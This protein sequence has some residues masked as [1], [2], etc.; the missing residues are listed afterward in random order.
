MAC[1][2][3]DGWGS[4]GCRD[5]GETGTSEYFRVKPH[6]RIYR[7][8]SRK[9]ASSTAAGFPALREST[10][11]KKYD[12]L[13]S[14]SMV[15]RGIRPWS[16]PTGTRYES[17]AVRFFDGPLGSSL[18]ANCSSWCASCSRS[19]MTCNSRATLC[20]VLYTQLNSR[21]CIPTSYS[22]GQGIQNGSNVPTC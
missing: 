16:I 9:S 5:G 21:C 8:S 22:G 20:V 4:G 17:T 12:R 18:S 7:L 3:V 14:C 1:V 6:T 2:V 11:G 10:R 19:S 15:L 13:F